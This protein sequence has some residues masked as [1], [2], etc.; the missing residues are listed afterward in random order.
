MLSAAAAPCRVVN[1]AANAMILP[2]PPGQRLSQPWPKRTKRCLAKFSKWVLNQDGWNSHLTMKTP[3]ANLLELQTLELAGKTP[4]ASARRITELRAQIPA[5]IV[6][7]YDRFMVRNKKGV[8][9]IKGQVC[10]ECHVQVPRNTVLTLMHGEDIQ[11][12]E[13]CGRYLCLP[14]PVPPAVPP[15]KAKKSP[16][17]KPALA[18]A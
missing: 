14:E 15:L 4:P 6:G 16:A 1:F 8:A 5:Q 2:V 10:G 12:C 13:N 11:V 3:T 17:K 18:A 9:V 7:H